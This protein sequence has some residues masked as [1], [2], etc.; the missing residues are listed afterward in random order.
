[1]NKDNIFKIQYFLV[2]MTFGVTTFGNLYFQS[3][4][5]TGTQIGF[6]GSVGTAIGLIALPIWGLFS[7]IF[8]SRK[9]IL[10]VMMAL[11]AVTMFCFTFFML[12]LT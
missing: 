8:Q 12:R 3:L 2:F 9:K 7:D 10:I 4:G 6:I 11:S 5:F 1:M